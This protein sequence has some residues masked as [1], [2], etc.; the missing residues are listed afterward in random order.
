MCEVTR[1]AAKIVKE[2]VAKFEADFGKKIT[3]NEIEA[4]NRMTR[5]W[6]LASVTHTTGYRSIKLAN[7]VFAGKTNSDAF[8]TT[9][10]HEFC[11]H[12][13]HVLNGQLGHGRTWKRM[14]MHF[15]LDP[16]R[17]VTQEAKEE[18]GYQRVVRRQNRYTH[19]CDCTSHE[20]G[21][22]VHA[23]IERGAKYRCPRCGSYV[24]KAGE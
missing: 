8:R 17:C 18:V 22:K 14:M 23:N 2:C 1:A 7:K 15:G 10:I 12:A 11:H 9:V 24:K 6:G 3:I 5:A 13:D 20:V 19:R 21:P 16:E 4:S